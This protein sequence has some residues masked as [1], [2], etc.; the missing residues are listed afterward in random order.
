M[1][2][3][4]W[5]LPFVRKSVKFRMNRKLYFIPG[6]ATDG[7]VFA[8]LHLPGY[9]RVY[10]DWFPPLAGEGIEGYALRMAERVEGRVPVLIGY[11]FGGIVAIEMAKHLKDATVIIV[12]SIKSFRERALGMWLTSS[13]GLHRL[14]PAGLG[15]ELRFAY[16]WM[17]DPKSP[18]ERNF[19]QLMKDSLDPVHTDWA[20][21]QAV[22]WRHEGH[23]PRLFH[24]HGD[25]D[26]I[27]PIRY[28]RN[29]IPIRGGTHLMLLNKGKEIG[30]HIDRIV[31]AVTLPR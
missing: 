20:I 15:K 11:S 28:I 17:N 6:V 10:L 18:A 16:T 19:I 27:F 25:Q 7:R 1:E 9:E 21:D 3:G 14:V 24:I 13:L 29:C 23:I 26:R 2:G 22:Q 4:L 30:N 8:E 31:Q 12:S 5:I